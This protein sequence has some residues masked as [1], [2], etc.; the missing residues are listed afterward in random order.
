[1]H[2]GRSPLRRGK[3]ANQADVPEVPSSPLRPTGAGPNQASETP[4]ETEPML[5]ASSPAMLLAARALLSSSLT[6]SATPQDSG[7]K[8][9]STAAP[10]S[11][12]Q[13]MRETEEERAH[14]VP[15]VCASLALAWLIV[16]FIDASAGC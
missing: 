16:S 4:R 14:S 7:T 8:R 15:L 2:V 3:S 10:T 5:Q 11:Q 12:R 13:H 1:M 6:W 9:P